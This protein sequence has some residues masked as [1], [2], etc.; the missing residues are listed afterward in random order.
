[1]TAQPKTT[2]RI[3]F[4][5]GIFLFFDLVCKCRERFLISV[6]LATLIVT[7]SQERVDRVLYCADEQFGHAVFS[8]YT[9]Q[10]D[11]NP[12]PDNNGSDYRTLLNA[13]NPGVAG[14]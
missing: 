13:K 3:V 10:K 9:V 4:G 8:V 5:E 7:Q 6:G 11:R 14:P 2:R 1:M 12:N